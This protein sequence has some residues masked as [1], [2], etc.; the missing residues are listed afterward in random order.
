[1]ACAALLVR[2][3]L[4]GLLQVGVDL[5]GERGA[6]GGY[7][8]EEGQAGAELGDRGRSE[9]PFRVGVDDLDER[10]PVGA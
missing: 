9:L 10:A 5:E 7:L 2:V 8:E 3:A 6:G 4:L 1:M